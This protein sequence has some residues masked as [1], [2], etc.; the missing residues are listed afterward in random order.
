MTWLVSK[1]VC[2]STVEDRHRRAVV[3][4]FCKCVKVCCLLG[5]CGHCTG[6]I[7]RRRGVAK[8]QQAMVCQ[9][10]H[11][12]VTAW[13]AAL[14]CL[15]LFLSLFV[16]FFLNFCVLF[17]VFFFLRPESSG[18]SAAFLSTSRSFS[19]YALLAA[20]VRSERSP[21]IGQ[22]ARPHTLRRCGPARTRT[23]PRAPRAVSAFQFQH[24]SKT[25]KEKSKV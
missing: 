24:N 22:Q 12:K 19:G 25:I 3:L 10:P 13:T 17:S 7:R 14:L 18:D 11:H 9:L 8:L 16:W 20:A 21:A 15:S 5:H 1:Y 6:L 4:S 23:P 2:W